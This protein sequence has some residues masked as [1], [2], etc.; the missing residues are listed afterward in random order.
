MAAASRRVLRRTA[1]GERTRPRPS[2]RD[3]ADD[4]SC[5]YRRTGLGRLNVEEYLASLA[6]LFEEAPDVTA[7]TLYIVAVE[8]HGLLLVAAKSAPCGRRPFESVYV[9]L[10]LIRGDRFVRG[11]CFEVED[12]DVRAR[13]S[14]SS[15][16]RLHHECAAMPPVPRWSA[17]SGRALGRRGVGAMARRRRA[18][19][20]SGS[21]STSEKPKYANRKSMAAVRGD[22]SCEEDEYFS[23]T[24]T[25]AGTP[26]TTAQELEQEA[27]WLLDRIG[28]PAG[29]RAVEIGCGPRGCLDLLAERVGPTGEVVGVERS[30]EAVDLA[31]K[32]IAERNL[33]NVRVLNGDARQTGLPR[34]QFD[35]A[36]ARLVLI[37]VP[38]PEE[39]VSEMAAL[40]RPGGVVALHEADWMASACDPP[41]PAWDRLNELMFAFARKNGND[42][43][44]G[45]RVPRMLREA[46]LVDVRSTRYSTSAARPRERFARSRREPTRARLSET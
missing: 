35:L 14:R 29:A 11:E 38:H 44:I 4:S 42:L 21:R 19:T 36:T 16:K 26:A 45:R 7:E 22:R 34:G 32:F 30:D 9:R 3:P 23:F 37:N 25:R 18:R 43:L 5:R 33:A 40:V 41:L 13:A 24:D 12:L 31:R 17:T 28:L 8:E 46:G 1:R 2:P 6:A 15:G 20:R 10:G 27:R 39:V